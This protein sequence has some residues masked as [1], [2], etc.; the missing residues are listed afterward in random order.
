MQEIIF[1]DHLVVVYGDGTRAVEDISFSVKEGEF[2]DSWVQMEPEEARPS[3]LS[4][5]CLERL[6]GAS[7]SRAST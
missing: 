3:R 6:Q 2:F 1:V 7:W 5:H 4:L